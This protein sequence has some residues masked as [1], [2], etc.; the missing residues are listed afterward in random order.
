VNLICYESVKDKITA[1]LNGL[2]SIIPI[3]IISIFN[4]EEFDFL[5]SGQSEIDLA[6]WKKNTIYKGIYNEGHKVLIP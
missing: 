6:D 5:L 1:L 4:A 3:D 2:R